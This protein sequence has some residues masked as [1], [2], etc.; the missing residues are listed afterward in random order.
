[1]ISGF[2]NPPFLPKTYFSFGDTRIPNK[3]KETY[4]NILETFYFINLTVPE[5]HGLAKI[6]G[7]FLTHIFVL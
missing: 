2:L 1:M 6:P 7:T 4:G 5:I 3:N